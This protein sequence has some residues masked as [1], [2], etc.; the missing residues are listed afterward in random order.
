MK[1]EIELNDHL[2]LISRLGFAEGALRALG[3]RLEAAS[4]E[5]FASEMRGEVK[6]C[7][8]LAD[9][10]ADDIGRDLNQ[11]AGTAP[12]PKRPKAIEVAK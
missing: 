5:T 6:E 7:A 11:V 12:M 10:S 8:R 9:Q 1:I 4:S 3:W 2:K